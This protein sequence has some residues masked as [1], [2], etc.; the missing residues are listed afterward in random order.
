[1][2]KSVDNFYV[3]VLIDPRS[4]QE[5]YYGQGQGDRRFAHLN[6][7]SDSQKVKIIQEIRSEGLEPTIR[8]VAKNLSKE[9]ALLIESTLIW[10]LGKKLTNRV[11]GH[12]ASHF[13]P[14]KT[15]HKDL[16]GFDFENS[17][18]LV[19]VGEG[20]IRNWDDCKK[21]GFLSAGQSWKKWGSKLRVLEPGD[22]V[23]A[24]LKHFGYAGIGKVTSKAVPAIE[25]R[26]NGDL[27][28]SQKLVQPEIVNLEGD[29]KDGEWIVGVQW[30]SAR[31]RSKAM[32]ARKKDGI[33]STTHIVASLQNQPRTV[34]IL[35]D[36]FAVN[37]ASLLRP[38]P[39]SN[40]LE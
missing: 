27:L 12:Y 38:S 7:R 13:R 20:E 37:F 1:M 39:T 26:T 29:K 6:D 30:I 10:K 17:L 9:Q 21:Y 2:A 23:A 16:S 22:I 33:F 34:R 18:Y 32:P 31:H 8:V 40:K 3:Y 24:Y 25:F 4:L 14:S 28:S 15:L 35:E 36:F 19:N 5:F 11:S